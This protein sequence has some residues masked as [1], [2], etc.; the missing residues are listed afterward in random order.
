MKLP[1]RRITLQQPVVTR[2]L[3]YG[4]EVTTWQDV[5]TVWAALTERQVAEGVDAAQRTM[6]RSTTVR[7]RYRTGV[8]N[9]WRLVLGSGAAARVLQI[10]GTLEIGR[11]WL[12]LMC[13]EYAGG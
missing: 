10:T 3:T 6:T 11:D 12:D 13:E 7:I 4:A 2:D 8:L 1:S 5:A 9:T